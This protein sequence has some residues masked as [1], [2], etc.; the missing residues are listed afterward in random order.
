M[1]LQEGALLHGEMALEELLDEETDI[2]LAHGGEEAQMAEI[3]T[4]DG[5]ER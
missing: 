1:E 5:R 4:H 3:D 2:L